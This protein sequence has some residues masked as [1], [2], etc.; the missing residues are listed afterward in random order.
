MSSTMISTLRH[1]NRV[2]DRRARFRHCHSHRDPGGLPQVQ[3]P[4]GRFGS[5]HRPSK[6]VPSDTIAVLMRWAT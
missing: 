3:D 1:L 5:V 4:C 2:G 6:R